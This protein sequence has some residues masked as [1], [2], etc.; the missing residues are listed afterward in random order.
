MSNFPISSSEQLNTFAKNL[1][2]KIKYP[3]KGKS[4]IKS[5]NTLLAAIADSI[6]N[7]N[8]NIHS[9]KIELDRPQVDFMESAKEYFNALVKKEVLSVFSILK[10]DEIYGILSAEVMSF[11]GHQTAE[12][13]FCLDEY[14]DYIKHPYAINEKFVVQLIKHFAVYSYDKN[15]IEDE[16]TK[17][18]K[19]MRSLLEGVIDVFIVHLAAICEKQEIIIPRFDDFLCNKKAVDEVIETEFS[20]FD[21]ADYY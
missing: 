5:H 10:P 16:V 1:L 4:A 15:S 8:H 2:T 11:E 6:P 18:Q 19:A 21:F 14:K 9:L 20:N 7:S 12:T 13:L 3:A 17:A